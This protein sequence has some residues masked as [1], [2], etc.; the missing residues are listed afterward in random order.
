MKE[1]V[2]WLVTLVGIAFVFWTLVRENDRRRK[3]S[4]EEFERDFAAGQGKMNQFIGAGG[5]GLES[6]LIGE[7][8]EAIAYKKD[9][10]QGMTRVGDKS[11]DPDRTVRER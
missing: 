2:I 3:R 5:L 9:E 8:R 11:D 6:I 1:T 4:V 10:E 7:K